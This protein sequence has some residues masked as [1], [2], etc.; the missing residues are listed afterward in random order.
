[1]DA[2]SIQRCRDAEMQRCQTRFPPRT[3][4]LR[5]RALRQERKAMPDGRDMHGRGQVEDPSN[6]EIVNLLASG[7]SGR[8]PLR[9]ESAPTPRV[10]IRI[11]ILGLDF[12]T[13]T[14]AD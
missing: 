5:I 9:L 8:E 2:P 12:P 6:C 14:G 3:R 7:Q 11:A 4:R 10:A 13:A 1:M